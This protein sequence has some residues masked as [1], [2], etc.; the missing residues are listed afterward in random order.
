ME[1]RQIRAAT[2]H[3]RFRTRTA[4][5]ALAILGL[6]LAG[7]ASEPPAPPATTAAAPIDPNDRLAP[8]VP[9]IREASARFDVPETWI[10]AVMI[11]ESGG[12]HWVNGRVITSRAGAI[13][14]MQVMPGTYDLMRK[15]YDLG[16]DPAD[17]R[18]NVMAGTA[19]IRE[20][21]D[22][23]GAPGF[24]AAYNCGPGCYANHLAG[25]QRLPQETRAYLAALSPAVRGAQP[26]G[27]PIAN[28]IEVAAV[29]E[30]APAP[31]PAPQPAPEVAAPAAPVA[32]V[33]APEAPAPVVV[34][35]AVPV[36]PAPVPQARSAPRDGA[37]QVA[38]AGKPAAAPAP[39]RPAPQPAPAVQLAAA[40]VDAP[41]A[42][43]PP[44][45]KPGTLVAAAPKGRTVSPAFRAEVAQAFL[46]AGVDPERV[47]FRFVSQRTDGCGSLK[48]R[49]SVCLTQVELN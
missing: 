5:G 37:F 13:G 23:F 42:S 34:A 4:F 25:K 15:A 17:P 14:L 27:A 35:E 24:L 29:P 7:C 45:R 38:M 6:T 21:Y 2:A 12:R 11:R 10:R 32:P 46:P 26:T 18:D 20:M 40:V 48:G 30:P 36:A 19:Y 44:Q 41:A 43:P 31:R 47:Q 28:A 9:H 3:G 39:V 33:A 16:S 1:L 22:L 49:D 8:W